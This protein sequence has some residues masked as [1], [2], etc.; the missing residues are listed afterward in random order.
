MKTETINLE[1]EVHLL[2]QN[3]LNGQGSYTKIAEA[4]ETLNTALEYR[5][6]YSDL[7]KH[8]YIDVVN[9]SNVRQSPFDLKFLRIRQKSHARSHHHQ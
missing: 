1:R 7:H 2:L 5:H 3:K 8:I 9:A 4:L 6:L